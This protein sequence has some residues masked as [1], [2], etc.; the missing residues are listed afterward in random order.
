VFHRQRVFEELYRFCTA[1]G[2]RRLTGNPLVFQEITLGDVADAEQ[3]RSLGPGTAGGGFVN[4]PLS[5]M[6]REKIPEEKIGLTLKSKPRNDGPT[7]LG[8]GQ[9]LTR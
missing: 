3:E 4:I 8:N 9:D 5:Y 2:R 1:A 7:A 6:D